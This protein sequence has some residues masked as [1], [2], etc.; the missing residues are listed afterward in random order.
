MAG[1]EKRDLRAQ[2]KARDVLDAMGREIRNARLAH[3]LSQS[4]SAR[5]MGKSASAWSRIERGAAATLSV[6]DLARALAVVGLELQLRAYPTGQPVRD[7]AHVLLLERLRASLDSAVRWQTEVPL[8]DPRDLRAW[9]ALVSVASARIGVEAETR[10]RDAQELQRRLALKRRD[11]RVD[12]VILLLADTRHN[13]M[14]V[15]AAGLGFRAEFPLDGRTAL[16]R[17]ACGED[18]GASAIILL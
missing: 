14:F 15:R 12:H 11:G 8:P 16:A 10:A 6:I 13:R 9:D 17:L 1:H 7:R 4:T 3:D 2:R 5:A 18:P